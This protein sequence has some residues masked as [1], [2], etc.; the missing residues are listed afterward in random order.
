MNRKASLH[1]LTIA[2][3]VYRHL[4]E[5]LHR[6]TVDLRTNLRA[7]IAGSCGLVIANGT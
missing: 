4:H 6:F 1:V 3:A 5:T 7:L 2:A